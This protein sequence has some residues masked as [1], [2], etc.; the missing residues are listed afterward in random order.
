LGAAVA[1][2]GGGDD[3]SGVAGTFATGKEATELDVLKG[4]VV[5]GDTNRRAG[6]GFTAYESG[7]VS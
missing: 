2:D 1:V 7:L 5:S 3:A 4:L 6:A